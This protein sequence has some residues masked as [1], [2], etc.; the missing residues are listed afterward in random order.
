MIIKKSGM[1]SLADL[2]EIQAWTHLFMIKSPIMHEDQ[3]R[4]FYYNMEF[5]EDEI[6]HTMVGD[7]RVHLNEKILWEILEVPREGIISVVGKLCTKHFANECSKLSDMHRQVVLPRSEKRTVATSI[8]LF[9]MESLC[10]FEALNLPALMLEHMHKTVVECKGKHDMWYVYFLTKVFDH[11]KV[12]VGTGTIC[13]V[14][15]SISLSTLVECEC[16][17]G[18]TGQLSKM[19]QLV[20]ERDQ[21][22]L[23]PKEMTALVGKKDIEMTLFKEKITKAQTEG[24]GTEEVKELRLKNAALLSQTDDLQKRLIKAHESANDRLTF[25]IKSLTH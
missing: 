16:I 8:D 24:P 22:K 14:K 5:N 6:L 15:Q 7:K 4:E 23:E 2:V 9:L 1:N 3:V 21:F 20:A 25:V 12:S 17:E 13:T 18:Q 19:S 10:K 11:L